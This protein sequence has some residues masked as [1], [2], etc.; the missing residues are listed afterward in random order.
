VRLITIF[1]LLVSICA[2][3]CLH[4]KKLPEVFLPVHQAMHAAT[5]QT[6]IRRVVILPVENQKHIDATHLQTFQ[7]E[8]AAKLREL[9]PFEIVELPPHLRPVCP[10]SWIQQGKFPEELLVEMHQKYAADGVMFVSINSLRSY[11]PLQLAAT[12]HLVD[13]NEAV[14]VSSVNGNW[15]LA[16]PE[17]L[18]QLEHRLAERDEQQQA[19]LLLQSPRYLMSFVAEEIAKEIAQGICR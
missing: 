11:P 18:R 10:Q 19:N 3:G 4:K 13:V 12:V 15:S 1:A 9:G 16:N 14:S 17:V 5:P 7:T 2:A 8:L 6:Q